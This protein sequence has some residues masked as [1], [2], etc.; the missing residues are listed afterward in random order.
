MN[1][2]LSKERKMKKLLFKFLSVVI[3]AIMLAGCI[4][5]QGCDFGRDDSETYQNNEESA[6]RLLD[7]ALK[8]YK[9]NACRIIS[10]NWQSES[11][12]ELQDM[13]ASDSNF[14]AL[15]D[16]IDG[17][18]R[19][20][21]IEDEFSYD[22]IIVDNVLYVV[23]EPL[24]DSD[25]FFDTYF[26]K[27]MHKYAFEDDKYDDVIASVFGEEVSLSADWFKNFTITQMNDG[28]IKLVMSEITDKYI[29]ECV[30]NEELTMHSY[31]IEIVF[32]SE[33]RFLSVASRFCCTYSY[34]YSDGSEKVDIEY[35]AYSY[36][37]SIYEYDNIKITAP[38]NEDEYTLSE[39]EWK[40]QN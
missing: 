21:N 16:E 28:K 3:V 20:R 11:E 24:S 7:K 13:V 15:V 31:D 25:V 14:M 26:L 32:D 38:E 17:K 35:T 36:T 5:L 37:E 4:A 18:N 6:Q 23:G 33:G 9:D 27:P 29:Q 10:K 39:I 22:Y 19:C 1:F 30:L 34:T 40:A 12:S 2:A 8:Y